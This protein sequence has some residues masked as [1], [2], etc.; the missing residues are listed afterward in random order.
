MAV[1]EIVMIGMDWT[2]CGMAVITNINECLWVLYTIESV[3]DVGNHGSR[4]QWLVS[5]YDILTND[6]V[7]CMTVIENVCMHTET[8]QP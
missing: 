7:W 8:V 3:A 6:C 2:A 1:I 4:H 5:G